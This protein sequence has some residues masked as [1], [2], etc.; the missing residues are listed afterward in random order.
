MNPQLLGGIT[1]N[2]WSGTLTG[3]FYSDTHDQLWS[4]QATTETLE[5][6]TWALLVPGFAGLWLWR[7]HGR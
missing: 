5:P 3:A 2:D 7:H 4:F 6:S 1:S